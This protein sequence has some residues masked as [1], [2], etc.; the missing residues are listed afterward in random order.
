MSKKTKILIIGN[1]FGGVYALK[2]LHKFLRGNK[3]I[4]L[5]MIGEKNYFLFTPLLH[6][7][8]TGGINGNN[9]IEPISKIWGRYLNDFYLGKAEEIN[10][11]NKTVLINDNIVSYDYLIIAP[12][13]ETNFFNTPGA[14]K[15]AFT[16]KSI[17]D[18]I[19]IKNHCINQM[20]RASHIK[21]TEERKKM[22]RFAVVGGG[23]TGVELVAE[24]EELVKETFSHYYQPEIIKDVSIMLIQKGPNLVPQFGE[25][26]RQK[27]LQVLQ[28]KGI[29]IM[30]NS[31]VKKI[32]SSY[33]IIN[34]DQKIF[35]ETVIWVAGI[36]PRLLKFNQ[37]VE[38][39]LD[40]K[41]VVNEYLQL[42]DHKE[43][44][45]IGDVAMFK[46]KN[47]ILPALAQVAE[48]ESKNV[49]KNIKNLIGEDPL[50]TFSYHNSG[51]L[52]S[53]GKW[54]AV[55]EIGNFSFSGH[56]AWWF[57]RTVYLS[58]LISFRKKVRVA[59]DWTMNIFSPRDISLL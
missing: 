49:A 37:N 46:D 17:D 51:N 47:I 10:L 8:A 18:A 13:S 57:W 56:I 45:A 59:V 2:N 35:T 3:N 22:L 50:Q 11:Q 52:M 58:K 25:K 21:D 19:R 38:Q 43:V 53:L 9:I 29:E 34:D 30:L 26:I 32:N 16:L 44:F 55:G 6:E 1:G 15:Y 12:G 39:S 40:G 28:K 7:V 5:S 20:E 33:V 14:D 27:S 31:A 48:K 23:P 4:E 42:K 36:K 24:M 41:L 54:M